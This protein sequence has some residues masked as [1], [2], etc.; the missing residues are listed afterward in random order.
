MIAKHQNIINEVGYVI[1]P[2]FLLS[3]ILSSM[4][5]YQ[6]MQCSVSLQMERKQTDT[7]NTLGHRIYDPLQGCPNEFENGKSYV[8]SR[9][10][11]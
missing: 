9:F 2:K 6:S 11:K 4:R 3:I 10:L 7:L 5:H 1:S 8:V